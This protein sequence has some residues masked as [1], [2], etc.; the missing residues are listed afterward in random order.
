MAKFNINIPQGKPVKHNERTWDGPYEEDPKKTYDQEG[1]VAMHARNTQRRD[2]DP[3]LQKE[4]Y[5]DVSDLDRLRRR[6]LY[7]TV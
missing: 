6:K 1:G 2:T 3:G 7:T 5:L 4:G